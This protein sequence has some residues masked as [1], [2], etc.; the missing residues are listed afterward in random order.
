MKKI[1]VWMALLIVS[2]GGVFFWQTTSASIDES[3]LPKAPFDQKVEDVTPDVLNKESEWTTNFTHDGAIFKEGDTYYV[4]S[5]DY[6]VGGPPTPG[7]QIRKSTDLI[8]WEFVGRVFDRVSEEA[9]AWAGGNT[10][11]APAITKIGDRFHLY[12]SV[13]G[14]GSRTSY[15]GLAT[16]STIEGPWEDEGAV[17]TSKDGDGGVANAIDPHVTQDA[18]GKWWMTYGSYFGGIFLTE[19]D[20]GTGKRVDESSEGTLLAKRKDMSMGIEGPEILYNDETGYYYLMVSYGWLED[21]YNVRIG[22]SKSIAGP[23]V[24]SRSRDL[25]DESD[26]SFDTGVKIVG[27]YRFEGDDGYVGTGHSAF[28]QDGTDTFV[29]H[30]ARPSEDIYWS[31]LHVRKVYWTKDGWPV[32][33]PER[34]A[35]EGNVEVD[36]AHLVGDWDVITFQRF[37]DGQQASSTLTLERGGK[38]EN[39]DGSWRLNGSVLEVKVGQETYE[40]Q[41]GAAWD[42]ENWQPT[43]IFTGLSEDGTAVWGKKR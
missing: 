37:D 29:L 24:D 40:T 6:M 43:I 34:Y 16:A 32:V 27:S 18:S 36:D 23:Y 28:L 26:E 38:L 22:R 5:T 11:W 20:P 25:R 4:F 13:S 41:V 10:F 35:G 17:V 30:Q 14:V 12:Y 31:Q 8:H 19:I 39:G 9:F 33:S 2:V 15:I 42:W 21:T 7:I 1:M 3:V